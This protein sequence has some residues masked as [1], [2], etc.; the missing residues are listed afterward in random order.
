[1]MHQSQ[2]R[3]IVVDRVRRVLELSTSDDLDHQML[4]VVT[5]P[6]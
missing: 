6:M 5:S 3:M 1:M 4:V 2:S